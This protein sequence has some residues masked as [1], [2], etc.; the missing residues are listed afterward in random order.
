MFKKQKHSPPL[1][2]IVRWSCIL[3]H[4]LIFVIPQEESPFPDSL[5]RFEG[6]SEILFILLSDNATTK[7]SIINRFSNVFEIFLEKREDVV[8]NG[9]HGKT[10][11][12]VSV[13]AY[14]F[15][16]ESAI[17]FNLIRSNNLEKSS[18][19][20]IFASPITKI[21]ETRLLSNHSP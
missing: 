3:L 12:S 15:H 9:V 10:P 14:S 2:H 18:K 20:L 21:C 7:I 19:M 11:M 16:H 5:F 8:E 1:N 13:A 6:I 17:L 4:Q